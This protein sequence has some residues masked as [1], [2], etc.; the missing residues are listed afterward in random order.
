MRPSSAVFLRAASCLEPGRALPLID[1]DG[2]ESG[3][4]GTSSIVNVFPL[5][6]EIQFWRGASPLSPVGTLL[7]NKGE[8]AGA[9]TDKSIQLLST[10]PS[11][12][13]TRTDYGLFCFF[14]MSVSPWKRLCIHTSVVQ[15][16]PAADRELSSR[17]KTQMTTAAGADGLS[18]VKWRGMLFDFNPVT[19]VTH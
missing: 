8:A 7:H 9:L 15:S 6:L 19:I 10:H 11:R 18:L 17:T 2:E 13:R 1:N 12:T 16:R 3:Q 5:K 4:E 14:P